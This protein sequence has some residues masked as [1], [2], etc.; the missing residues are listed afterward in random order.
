MNDSPEVPD[1]DIVTILSF[2]DVVDGIGGIAFSLRG[3]EVTL[4]ALSPGMDPDAPMRVIGRCDAIH[5]AA[6]ASQAGGFLAFKARTA[7]GVD[8]EPVVCASCGTSFEPICAGQAYGCA[9]E[10]GPTAVYGHYGSAVADMVE[11]PFKGLRP[12][13]VR[14]GIVCDVCIRKLIEEE[15]FVVVT[16]NSVEEDE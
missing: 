7:S 14:D 5:V 13:W 1:F 2:K 10:A 8:D 3:T 12:S 16:E 11:F 15:A 6:A 9:A 4:H